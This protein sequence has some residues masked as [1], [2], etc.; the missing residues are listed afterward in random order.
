MQRRFGVVSFRLTRRVVG[1]LVV[2][3]TL[4]VTVCGSDGSSAPAPSSTSCV[5]GARRTP[6]SSADVGT[7]EGEGRTDICHRERANDVVLISV[8]TL[9]ADAN[10]AR[11]RGL[12]WG[13][14]P[15]IPKPVWG[16]ASQLLDDRDEDGVPDE[17]DNCQDM[18][19]FDQTDR[20]GDGVGDACQPAAER[21]TIVLSGDATIG[22]AL[23]A[24]G[25]PIPFNRGNVTFF[26]NVL[27]MNAGSSVALSLNR[28]PASVVNEVLSDIYQ[29]Y[30][31]AGA[32]V[33]F[34]ATGSISAATLDAVAL[35]VILVPS[36]DF[37][38]AE[39]TAMSEFLGGGGTVFFLGESTNFLPWN[40]RIN[41][42]LEF[43]GS[44]M[45]IDNTVVGRAADRTD[46]LA[47]HP[48]LF[49]ITDIGFAVISTISGGM[50]LVS[51]EL[52]EPFIA[53]D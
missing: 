23:V 10:I 1:P 43:L 35:L 49:G 5:A 42:T 41:D 46:N 4:A 32:A 40:N 33:S 13:A 28:A 6:R 29:T 44:S 26:Q 25:Q 52:D 53:V 14:V 50:T 34:I 30:Q 45:R 27:T 3:S 9:A 18:P 8:G 21:G 38:P 47:A 20:D 22:S 31:D 12:V 17:E 2:A 16:V 11:D 15:D 19:T 51:S 39:L 36:V 7:V 48:L 37:T 24:G